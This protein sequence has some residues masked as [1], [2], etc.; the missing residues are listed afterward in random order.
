L[1]VAGIILC[2]ATDARAAPTDVTADTDRTSDHIAPADQNVPLAPPADHAGP[3]ASPA[4][5]A[6]PADCTASPE[7]DA[8]EPLPHVNAVSV[9]TTF[10]PGLLVHGSGH[11]AGGDT[12]TGSRLLALEGVGLGLL[13]AGFVPIVLTGT[14]RRVVGTAAA[15]TVVG[16]GLFAISF[17]ADVYGMAAPAGGFGAPPIFT[18]VLQTALGYRYV[19]DPVFSYRQFLVQDID[20]RTGPWRL[21]PSAWFALD[22]TNARLRAHVAYRLTGP[23][24]NGQPASRDGSFIDIEGALTRHAFTSNRFAITT[25]EVAI[26]G[27]F[28]MGRIGPSL[29]GS[30]AEM[31]VGV[32]LQVYAYDTTAA[33]AD[34]EDLLLARFGYGMYIGR[35]GGP[36]GEMTLYYDHRHDEFA[37]G[38][39]TGGLVSGVA[40]HFGIAAH[41][42]VSDHW[43]LAAEAAVGSAYVTGLSVLFRHGDPL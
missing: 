30:F 13:A 9:T 35:I 23:M 15:L 27:R 19:Y 1:V 43:G 40:G 6:A 37:A 2:P 11:L 24:P 25:A 41:L 22:D 31:G 38:L 28:D 21:H 36:R 32:A 39:K 3:P 18:P 16:V 26:A 42:Y 29:R 4:D 7:A 12:K 33:S 20:V 17:L 34:V 5:R 14:S 8:C 10:L